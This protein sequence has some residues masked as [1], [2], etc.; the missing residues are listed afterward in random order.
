MNGRKSIKAAVALVICVAMEK[1]YPLFIFV[2]LIAEK[3]VFLLIQ[4][5][6]F[7]P[8]SIKSEKKMIN[9]RY[10]GTDAVQRPPL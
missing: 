1:P 2:L 10:R 9:P 6:I 7:N 8:K 3:F 4:L 5:P